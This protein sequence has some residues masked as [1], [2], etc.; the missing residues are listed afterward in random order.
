MAS[1]RAKV[2]ETA[3]ARTNVRKIARG[4]IRTRARERAME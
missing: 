1:S 2:R 4:K 3:M